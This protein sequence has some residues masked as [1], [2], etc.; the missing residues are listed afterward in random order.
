MVSVSSE[1]RKVG[2][3]KWQAAS[4]CGQV[5]GSPEILCPLT[6]RRRGDFRVGGDYS[7]ALLSGLR[8]RA[9][10]T[11]RKK[12]LIGF[13]ATLNRDGIRYD[14]PIVGMREQKPSMW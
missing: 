9:V 6:G 14:Y 3:P 1:V 8:E 10:I 4:L 7:A 11:L 13:L 12:S 2:M 5:E